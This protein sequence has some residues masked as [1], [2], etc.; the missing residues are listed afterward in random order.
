MAAWGSIPGKESA[1]KES[2]RETSE[3]LM[4]I[5]P[6]YDFPLHLLHCLFYIILFSVACDFAT[7]VLSASL[8][9]L[10][11][12]CLYLYLHLSVF[13]LVVIVFI[14]FFSF[15]QWGGDSLFLFLTGL[16]PMKESLLFSYCFPNSNRHI[17]TITL[18]YISCFLPQIKTRCC[19]S[20]L[21]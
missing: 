3:C 5:C 12:G 19:C 14:F 1:V 4:W 16:D 8:Q 21:L 13:P 2:C 7:Y 20:G 6:C 10:F 11:L 15:F 9:S 18:T 17:H